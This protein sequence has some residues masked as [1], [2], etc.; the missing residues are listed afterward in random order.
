MLAES[1]NGK[2]P[3]LPGLEIA[4]RY[5]AA[6]ES[7]RFG[8][9][10]F[11]FI[12]FGENRLGLVMADVCGKGLKAGVFTA[13]AKYTVRAFSFPE[14]PPEFIVPRVNELMFRQIGEEGMFI[15]MAFVTL[16]LG[17]M[18]AQYVNAGHCSPLLHRPSTGES[19]LLGPT[20]PPLGVFAR[21]PYRQQEI[22]LESGDV[23]VLVTDGIIDAAR[24]ASELLLGD[25]LAATGACSDVNV[26]ADAIIADAMERAK[27]YQL[28]DIA[29]IVIRIP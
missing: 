17:K 8:G 12:D 28:D 29:L 16:D 4:C 3:E 15:T 23:L 10:Y 2:A 13:M 18:T 1:F 21:P 22:A 7:E 5:Q 20:G 14:Q 11:D 26:L 9:D 25:I 6:Y 24:D 19:H 27:D